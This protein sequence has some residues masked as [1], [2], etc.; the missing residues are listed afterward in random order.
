MITKLEL[1][2]AAQ[3]A[4]AKSLTAKTAAELVEA[5]KTTFDG[6]AI[7]KK[8]WQFFSDH[9]DG[10]RNQYAFNAR[11]PIAADHPLDPLETEAKP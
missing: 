9:F 6:L 10:A 2:L 1:I 8:N 4:A 5:K 7:S 3:A 11:E